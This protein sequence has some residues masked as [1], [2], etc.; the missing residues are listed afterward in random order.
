[1]GVNSMFNIKKWIIIL[2]EVWLFFDSSLAII[3]RNSDGAD[4]FIL[5]G[6]IVF[7]LVDILRRIP[8]KSR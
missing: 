6:M 8:R 1:M 7:L 3:S 5:I 4:Y 2:G